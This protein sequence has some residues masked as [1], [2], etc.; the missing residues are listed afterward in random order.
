MNAEI[1]VLGPSKD[2]Y[3]IML[4]N[5][6]ET[7]QPKESLTLAEQVVV[8]VKEAIKW[9]AEN[10]GLE[11]LTDPQENETSAE[12]NSSVILLLQIEGKKFLFTGDAGVEAIN[13]AIKKTTNLGIDLKALNFIQ[14]PHH[15]SKH[16]IGPSLLDF[17]VGE[18]LQ[19]PAHLKTAF[20]S[21]PKDGDP[22][23][24]SRKVVNAFMRRGVKVLATKDSAK[25]HFENAPDR[26]WSKA[27]PLP[28]YDKVAE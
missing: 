12:N 22:K 8:A 2:F 4:A 26:G 1:V 23:H 21:S 7:P 16:N 24:P 9:V 28:F 11:T 20:V 18:K 14:I 13:E 10:W 25:R 6:R 15:G 27:E 17:I 5:F 3:S 19:E